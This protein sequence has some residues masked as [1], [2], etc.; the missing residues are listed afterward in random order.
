M[1]QAR[2]CLID[3]QLKMHFV[4][5]YDLLDVDGEGRGIYAREFTEHDARLAF[6]WERYFTTEPKK[7]DGDLDEWAR[8]IQSQGVRLIGVDKP[9]N[10]LNGAWKFVA[11]GAITAGLYWLWKS[12][13]AVPA[14]AP[15][16]ISPSDVARVVFPEVR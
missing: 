10:I 5:K 4:R 13:D 6:A 12:D 11:G 3:K 15:E 9:T 7:L 8:R 2:A 16:V 1:S 14:I